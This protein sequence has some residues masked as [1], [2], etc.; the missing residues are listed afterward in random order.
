MVAIQLL[1]SRGHS[2]DKPLPLCGYSSLKGLIHF[3]DKVPHE[4]VN[5]VDLSSRTEQQTQV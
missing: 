3:H 1:M 2:S 4:G 5:V